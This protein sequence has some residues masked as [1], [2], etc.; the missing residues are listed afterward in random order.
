VL[1][2]SGTGEPSHTAVDKNVEALAVEHQSRHDVL[3]PRSREHKPDL[4]NRVRAPRRPGSRPTSPGS[5]LRTLVEGVRLASRS[6]W[7]R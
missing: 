1:S 7:P 6:L 3:E 5:K 2:F 4:R